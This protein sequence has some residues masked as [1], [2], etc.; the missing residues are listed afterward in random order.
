MARTDAQRRAKNNYN[1]RRMTQLAIRFHNEND[2]DIIMQ[3]GKQENKLRYIK[4][5]IR[6]DIERELKESENE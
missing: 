6:E 5:L 2:A 1:K 4:R 3:L